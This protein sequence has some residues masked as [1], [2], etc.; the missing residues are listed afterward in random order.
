MSDFFHSLSAEQWLLVGFGVFIIVFLFIDLG[1]FQKR[2]HKVGP[3]RALLQVLFWI[4]MAASFAFLIA[5]YKGKEMA[6]QFVAAYITEKSL[7]VD[8][9]FFFIFIFRYFRISEHFHHKVFFYRGLGDIIFK[10]IFI[11]SSS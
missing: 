2:A 6:Y 7:S 5:L 3:Q 10:G 1:I 8:K 11:F 4:F 9:M